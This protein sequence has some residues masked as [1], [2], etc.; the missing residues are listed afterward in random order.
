QPISF[1]VEDASGNPDD[2]SFSLTL[3]E[4]ADEVP[5]TFIDCPSPNGITQEAAPGL[6]GAVVH[7]S[8]PEATD[9]EGNPV[10]VELTSDLGPG[11]NFPIGP[12]QVSFTA[13][14][15][16]GLTATCTFTVNI[17]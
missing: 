11:D 14:G 7:F 4:Y 2:C 8:V 1:T 13:K 16:N 6:C 3:F 12:T 10:S 17:I 15:E 9:S 5:P